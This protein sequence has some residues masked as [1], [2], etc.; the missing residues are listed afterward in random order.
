MP[1]IRYFQRLAVPP[2]L[3]RFEEQSPRGR[4]AA[5]R[6]G[7]GLGRFEPLGGFDGLIER[8]PC[9]QVHCVGVDRRVYV[10]VPC[11]N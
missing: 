10:R 2:A 9:V 8:L 4:I 1:L 7:R 3:Q 5:V 6:L 11:G